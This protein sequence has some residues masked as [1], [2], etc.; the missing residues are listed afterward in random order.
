[1]R[2]HPLLIY[3]GA[4]I[5][6][7]SLVLAGRQLAISFA[8]GANVLDLVGLAVAIATAVVCLGVLD[9]ARNLPRHAATPAQGEEA[10]EGSPEARRPAGDEQLIAAIHALEG[11]ARTESATDKLIEGATRVVAD[12][13]GASAVALW[14]ADA[15]GRLRLRAD[16]ADGAVVLHEGG[17]PDPAD[18]ADLQQLLECRRPLE[19]RADAA[20]RFLYP[21][22][23][24]ERCDGALRV[25]VPAAALGEGPDVLV[26]LS[27]RLAH[28]AAQAARVLAAPAAYEQALLDPVS[29]AYSRRHMLDRLGSATALC[30]RYGEP[31]SLVVLDVDNFG[32]LNAS[33]GARAGDRLLHGVASLVKQN[34]RDADS[35]YR[36]GPDE[37]AVLLPST[38]RDKARAVAERLCRVV[39]E[40]RTLAD[41]GAALIASVSA[42]VVEFDEDM[43]GTA[44]LLERARE[45]LASARQMGRDRVQVWRPPAE[46][47]D[48]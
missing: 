9:W 16:F 34:V 7:L 33:F 41:D 14:L 25:T 39:R 2:L 46:V 29:G 32:M 20:A 21:L 28:V 10:P 44:P 17:T 4:L 40:N 3:A 35:V 6:V 42:G 36:S 47:T 38:E 5:A 11:L 24:A 8:P 26:R 30:R 12:F 19:A 43:R 1:M 48:A 18:E 15:E 31:L 37:F 27:G 45:A 22:L 13:A 23:N